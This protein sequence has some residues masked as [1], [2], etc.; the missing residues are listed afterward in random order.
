MNNKIIIASDKFRGSL[1]SQELAKNLS[2]GLKSIDNNLDI[3]IVP[4]SDGGD[5]LLEVGTFANYKLHHFLAQGPCGEEL[6]THIGIKDTTAIIELSDTAGLRRLKD[7]NSRCALSASSY[8]VGQSIAKAL[9]LG[10]K[11]IIIGLGGSASTDGGTAML[12]ALG[13]K[14][15]DIN[16]N[17]LPLGG[18]FLP[19]LDHIDISGLDRRLGEVDIMVASD[20]SNPLLG[21]QGAARIYGPQKGASSTEVEILELGLFRLSEVVQK[22]LG[23]DLADASGAGAAGGVGYGALIGLGAKIDSGIQIALDLVN[24]DKLVRS[25]SLVITGEGSLDSQTLNGKAPFG[26]AQASLKYQVPV[27]AITGTCKLKKEELKKIGISK[28]YSLLELE[29]N[30]DICFKKVDILTEKI[31]K[32]IAK[33]WLTNS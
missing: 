14:F 4:V 17:E 28:C 22:D 29:P 18:G 20:V 7:K 12:K 24:F 1:S 9:D 5:G 6:Q 10:C 19:T 13:A 3:V 31:G 33:E 11:K 8:G 25:S 27:I 15:F 2:K 26:V 23:L 21:V 32:I 30:L 16:H